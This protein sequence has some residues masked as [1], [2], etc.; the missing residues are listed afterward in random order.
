MD[1][2]AFPSQW[3]VQGD[4]AEARLLTQGYVQT[5]T[6]HAHGVTWVHMVRKDDDE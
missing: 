5:Q 2:I 6:R 3:V 4:T 1:A